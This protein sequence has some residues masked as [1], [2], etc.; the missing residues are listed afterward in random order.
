[1]AIS[2][3]TDPALIQPLLDSNLK[4]PPQVAFEDFQ[5]CDRFDVRERLAEIKVPVLVV[6]GADDLLHPPQIC[7]VS[8]R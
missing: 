4:T 8:G 2:R 6:S 5:A 1:M 7:R 3:K